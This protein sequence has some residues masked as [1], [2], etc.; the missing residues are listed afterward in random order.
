MEL[1]L[2]GAALG[3]EI[4]GLDLAVPLPTNEREQLR[5]ALARHGVLFVRGQ[6]LAPSQFVQFA[7]NFGEIERYDSTLSQY[8]LPGQP[9]IIVLS[10]IEKDGKPI[11]VVDAGTYWHT[12]RSYV[13]KPAWS[14]C[15]YAVEV[16]HA[17]DGTPLGDTEFSSTTAAY[18]ALPASDCEALERLSAW[19]EYV[20]RFSERNESMPGVS[21]PVVLAHPL[22]GARCLY[23]NQGFTHHI[24][25]LPEDES[26]RLIERL[27]E[28][29][30][31]P[32][33]V[34]RHRW[35]VG[36]LLLWDN[37]STQ[38]RATGG[39]KLPQRRHMWRTTIQ[40]FALQRGLP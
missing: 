30:R 10:N 20:F 17:E 28:H 32:Q 23:V 31:Q 25:D 11:G 22:T 7:R 1:K 5:D 18:E 26:T 36:D 33:F 3:A 34:Y 2:T 8:L 13:A 19:H 37:Y 9:E 14:S 16:P 4:V 21:H 15:L 24:L 35:K 12:D 39:Y 40:G 38:H 29:V 27:F 6:H